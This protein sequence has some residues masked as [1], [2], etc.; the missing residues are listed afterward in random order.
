MLNDADYIIHII[1]LYFYFYFYFSSH[2]F[3]V[4]PFGVRL[5]LVRCA[6]GGVLDLLSLPYPRLLDCRS[7]RLLSTYLVVLIVYLF[8]PLT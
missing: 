8:I 6:S 7:P 1:P 2:S 4:V 5:D 3:L